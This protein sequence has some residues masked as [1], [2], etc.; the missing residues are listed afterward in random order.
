M[1]QELLTHGSKS[2]MRFTGAGNVLH[3]G[4]GF[5]QW[6][7]LSVTGGEWDGQKRL[8]PVQRYEGRD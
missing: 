5:R 8:G 2:G 7:G 6:N 4:L 1:I 3:A